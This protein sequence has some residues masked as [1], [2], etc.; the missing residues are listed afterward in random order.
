MPLPANCRKT[1]IALV[2]LTS[3]TSTPAS[4]SIGVENGDSRSW[5]RQFENG[6][7]C[8]KKHLYYDSEF[9]FLESLDS[10][11]RDLKQ[12]LASLTALEELFEETQNYK[13]KELV[14]L[15]HLKIA[16]AYRLPDN[17]LTDIHLQLGDVYSALE[18][19]EKAKENFY[20]ALKQISATE[21]KDDFAVGSILNNLAY[22]EFRL[23]DFAN[24]ELHYK[25]ALAIFTQLRGTSSVCFGLAAGNLADL[26]ECTGRNKLALTY[27]ER[28][29]YSL[30]ESV[31]RQHPLVKKFEHRAFVLKQKLL[32]PFFDKRQNLPYPEKQFQLPKPQNDLAV[33][34]ARPNSPAGGQAKAC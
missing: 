30:N 33:L 25:Q 34:P 24:A 4:A 14:L 19:Y 2:S 28:A 20:E 23:R 6:I 8:L 7:S 31:G 22:C 10:A 3:L 12:S 27:F 15:S 16:R 1:I 18:K 9:Y 13:A 21:F 17:A 32:N 26:Y 11:G 5:N 29:I